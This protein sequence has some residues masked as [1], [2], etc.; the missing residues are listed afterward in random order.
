MT[1]AAARQLANVA[2]CAAALGA[3]VWIARTPALRRVAFGLAV[4]ALTTSLP[5]WLRQEV[6]HAW[7]ESG[8][9]SA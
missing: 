2:L 8:R 9:R 1:E 5:F 6:Q 4:T 3:A 7:S